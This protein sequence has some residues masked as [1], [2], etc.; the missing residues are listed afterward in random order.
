MLLH[1]PISL[2]SLFCRNGRRDI[3][4]VSCCKGKD[5]TDGVC[6]YRSL[7]NWCMAVMI[8]SK[9]HGGIITDDICYKTAITTVMNKVSQHVEFVEELMSSLTYYFAAPNNI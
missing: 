5:I 1:V 8:Q 3:S 9:L 7:E 2:I 6:G 4:L